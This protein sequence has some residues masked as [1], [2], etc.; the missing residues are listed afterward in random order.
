MPAT[1]THSLVFTDGLIRFR[2]G[3]MVPRVVSCPVGSGQTHYSLPECL[4]VYCNIQPHRTALRC[5]VPY[6]RLLG[7]FV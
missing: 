7:A 1:F 6:Q 4:R 5:T 2:F 3:S